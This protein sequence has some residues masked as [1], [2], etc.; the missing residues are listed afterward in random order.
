[1]KTLPD[2]IAISKTPEGPQ[3]LRVMLAEL[4]GREFRTETWSEY[5]GVYVNNGAFV[6]LDKPDWHPY[7]DYPA[8]LNAI[9]SQ[10]LGVIVLKEDE[11]AYT[12]TLVAV[13]RALK[14]NASP[15]TYP[16]VFEIATASALQHTV[17]LIAPCKPHPATKDHKKA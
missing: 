4:D 16:S 12:D 10:V 14:P 2:L 9:I 7:P 15:I 11:A 6:G 5:K 17:A 1:M 3:Q 8:D 13:I